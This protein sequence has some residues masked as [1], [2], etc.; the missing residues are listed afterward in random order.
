MTSAES[1][2]FGRGIT[3]KLQGFDPNRN[4]PEARSVLLFR[5]RRGSLADS[6]LS[7]DHCALVELSI[8]LAFGRTYGLW[9]VR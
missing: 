9:Q 4:V 6:G 7:E 3:R 2:A 8:S 5:K 1:L